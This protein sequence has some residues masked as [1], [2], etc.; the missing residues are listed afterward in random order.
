MTIQISGS[1]EQHPEVATAEIRVRGGQGMK[2]MVPPPHAVDSGVGILE[3]LERRLDEYRDLLLRSLDG[4]TEEEAATP[5]IAGRPSLLGIVRHTGFVQGVWLCEAVTGRTRQ[6]IGIP[7]STA[8][9]WKTRRTDTI[10]SV[11]AERR[12]IDELARL[13]IRGRGPESVVT[14]RGPRTV[15]SLLTHV[16][17]ELA[18]NTGQSDILRAAILARRRG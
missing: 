1:S 13:H 10:R 17:S 16:L 6:E 15:R 11:I 12:R 2:N 5:L 9:S 7:V 8:N 14:G 3:D 4:L 18:W